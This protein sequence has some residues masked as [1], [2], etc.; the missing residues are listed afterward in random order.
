MKIG[1]MQPYFFPYIGYFQLINEVD[2]FVIYDDVNYIN[3]GWINRN[4]IY[5]NG[6]LQMI[7][8]N[9]KKVSQNKLINEIKIIDDDKMRKKIL[10]SL[11]C[12]YS[13]APY[14]KNVYPILEKII[15]N[16]E[17]RLFK[18]LEYSL[19]EIC[20][21]LEINT[22]IV[23]SSSL[24]KCNK[25]KSKEKIINI[26]KILGGDEYINPIGGKNLYSKQTFRDNGI[27]L[28]FIKS[29]YNIKYHQFKD[30]FVPNLSI[31]DVLMFN[32]KYDIQ[33][34]LNLYELI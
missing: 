8:L 30:E 2:K 3:R 19:K 14:Y 26:C 11:R 24:D 10:K 31:I 18:Y 9:L 22:D 33:N 34:M 23:M 17:H 29:D 20:D 4:Y 7:N 12:I 25:L 5:N 6:D 28:S 32:S 27:K 1:I 16:S 21:Y 15:L 13:K